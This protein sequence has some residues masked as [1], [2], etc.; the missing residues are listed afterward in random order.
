M[1]TSE[2]SEQT[3]IAWNW[4]QSLTISIS[5]SSKRKRSEVVKTLENNNSLKRKIRAFS[6]NFL[7][8]SDSI[9]SSLFRGKAPVWRLVLYNIVV[10][11]VL[12][13]GKDRPIPRNEEEKK[14]VKGRCKERWLSILLIYFLTSVLGINISLYKTYE[15]YHTRIIPTGLRQRTFSLCLRSLYWA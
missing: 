2:R 14:Y 8:V 11:S 10:Y 13:I 6:L 3:H 9:L 7:H 1:I 12:A 15:K 5:Y 4:R